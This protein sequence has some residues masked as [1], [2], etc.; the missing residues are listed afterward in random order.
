MGFA[1][2]D[3]GRGVNGRSFFGYTIV[4]FDDG[5]LLWLEPRPAE[6]GLSPRSCC[7]GRVESPADPARVRRAHTRARVRR[8]GG[9]DGAAARSSL[10]A[11]TTAA[12]TAWKDGDASPV[13]PEPRE[14]NALRYADGFVAD[15][16]RDLRPR[17]ARAPRSSTSSSPSRSTAASRGRPQ[18][19]RLLRAPRAGPDGRLAYLAVGP[20]AAAVPRL[21]AVGRRRRIAGGAGRGRLPAGVGAGRRALLGLRP[22][23]AGGTSYRDGERLTALE[24]ELGYPFW[25]FGLRTYASSRTAASRAP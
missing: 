1:D 13:T 21:R 9:L 8:R 17:V 19:P 4:D 7:N 2:L 5:G 10:R 20:S 23:T 18:R 15:G 11:S 25:V 16:R 24:A 22:G 14:P 6:G 12:S 3:R